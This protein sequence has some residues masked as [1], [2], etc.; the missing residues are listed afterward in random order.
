MTRK[1][2]SEF[3][4]TVKKKILER[5]G[6]RCEWCGIDFDDDFEGEFHHIIPIINGGK[7]SIENCSLLCPNCHYVAPNLKGTEELPI[8]YHYFIKFASFK[9][10]SKYYNVN[11]RIELYQKIAQDIAKI[12]KRTS[13]FLYK[14]V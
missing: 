2:R 7:N 10:A 3:P 4:L 13:W 14:I 12:N 6:N 8:Y 9:E 5:T 11:T 1:K